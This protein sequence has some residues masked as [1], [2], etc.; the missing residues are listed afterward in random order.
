MHPTDMLWEAEAPL[1]IQKHQPQNHSTPPGCRN[2]KAARTTAHKGQNGQQ[3][4]L[5]RK[6]KAPS[7]QQQLLPLLQSLE[8]F[9]CLVP[10][11]SA[12]VYAPDVF[13]ADLYAAAAIDT[14]GD[15]LLL[16]MCC[17]MCCSCR[18][19]PTKQPLIMIAE[20]TLRSPSKRC[21]SSSTSSTSKR[22]MR[23]TRAC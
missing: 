17:A 5:L 19:P 10:A 9:G 2:R 7:V 21:G 20:R 14:A 22:M 15:L 4:L 11:A 18:A 16:P 12:A 1:K 6:H 8:D 23:R 13:P 3:L